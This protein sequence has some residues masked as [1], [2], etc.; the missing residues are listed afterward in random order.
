MIIAPP[1][2]LLQTNPP[3]PIA[4]TRIGHQTY[5]RDALASQI[6]VS[7]AV[8]N[9]PKDAPLRPDTFEYWE[10]DALPATWRIDL[11]TAQNIDYIGIAGHTIGT[12]SATI[13]VEYSDDDIYWT[14]FSLAT[15]PADDT[16][17]MFLNIPIFARYIRVNVSSS[18]SPQVPPRIGVIYVGVLLAMV[19]SLYGGHAPI[20]LSR[21]TTLTRALSDGGQFLGQTFR[22]NGVTGSAAFQN[23]KAAWIRQYFDPFI[24]DARRYPFFFA[25]S[26]VKFPGEV[27][28]AWA[29]A[30]ISPSNMGLKDF[31]SVSWNMRGIGSND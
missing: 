24:R 10:P 22:R 21:D 13:S 31:M 3:V 18:V 4:H 27:I 28:Y 23:L 1:A 25:W 20:P 7:G 11:L 26:P 12:D 14:P 30:D 29:T 19:R 8:L 2:F 17:I 15:S 16:P 6:A 5:T 9:A